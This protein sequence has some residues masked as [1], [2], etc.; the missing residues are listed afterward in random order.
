MLNLFYFTMHP[1]AS[2]LLQHE[3]RIYFNVTEAEKMSDRLILSFHRF[4]E[5]S[6]PSGLS[7]PNLT[8]NELPRDIW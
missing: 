3:P 7:K 5:Y 8:G 2:L 6:E 4:P 1:L